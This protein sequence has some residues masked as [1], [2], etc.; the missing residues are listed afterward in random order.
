MLQFVDAA[1]R[2]FVAR[3]AW[4]LI[5]HCEVSRRQQAKAHD[6]KGCLEG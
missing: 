3:L 1:L 2:H 5:S 6:I 4:E